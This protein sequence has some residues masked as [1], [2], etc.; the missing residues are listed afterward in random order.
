MHKGFTSFNTFFSYSV[1]NKCLIN[2]FDSFEKNFNVKFIVCPVFQNSLS[3]L[4][5]P[6]SIFRNIQTILYRRGRIHQEVCGTRGVLLT[7]SASVKGPCL[8]KLQPVLQFTKKKFLHSY[9]SRILV[10]F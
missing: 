9:F 6:F 3:V 7:S 4:F 5:S 2:S 10:K 8:V 1:S